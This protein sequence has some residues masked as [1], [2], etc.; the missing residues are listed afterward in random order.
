[1]SR[2]GFRLHRRF[3]DT[4]T[5]AAPRVEGGICSRGPF[6]VS[7]PAR[8]SRRHDRRLAR[9]PPPPRPEG[10]VRPRARVG[11]EQTIF[12]S[13][14]VG[15]HLRDH[16][17]HCRRPS[18]CLRPQ[19]RSPL[20]R[21]R[22]GRLLTSPTLCPSSISLLPSTSMWGTPCERGAPCLTHGHSV[23]SLPFPHGVPCRHL[24]LPP[25][26][27]PQDIGSRL[28]YAFN[29]STSIPHSS[30]NLMTSASAFVGG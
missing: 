3:G 23:A 17:P 6:P 15:E 9:Y 20:P 28:L 29:T 19:R 12:C 18:L 13:R 1:M 24:A 11:C 7:S 2:R 4:S 22:K 25:P 30:V 27:L 8:R 16:Y 10:R 21:A 26:P 14:R 5:R